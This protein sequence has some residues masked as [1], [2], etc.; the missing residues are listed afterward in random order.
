M[1]KFSRH[2]KLSK[3]YTH[4]MIVDLCESMAATKNSL[5]A[6]KVLSDLLGKQELE[7]VARRL[8]IAQFLLKDY[9]YESIEKELKVSSATIARVESWLQ[10]SGEGYRMIV[11]RLKYKRNA[12]RKQQEPVKLST[13][14]KKYP[15]Y[16]WP[17]IILQY[18]VHHS[19]M[20]EKKEMQGILN[21]LAHKQQ[22][23]KEL[24]QLLKQNLKLTS[25]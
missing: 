24:E 1:A 9:T 15:I 2:Q 10:E 21:K 6:A 17:Q 13:I 19:T 16:Y 22:I 25:S 11:E 7:M 5:E 14:K 18:W 23:N 8:K 3:E 20:K 12:R 4:D